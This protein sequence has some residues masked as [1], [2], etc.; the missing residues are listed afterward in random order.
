M[1]EQARNGKE[2]LRA[3]NGKKMGAESA[4][5]NARNGIDEDDDEMKE[6]FQDVAD[7]STS[8][9]TEASVTDSTTQTTAQTNSSEGFGRIE[10]DSMIPSAQ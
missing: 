10:D 3:R 5:S 4:E 8:T 2:L 6:W 1:S 7:A 9:Q